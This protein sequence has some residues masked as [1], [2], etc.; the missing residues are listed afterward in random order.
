MEPKLAGGCTAA[1][2]VL[3]NNFLFVANVGDSRVLVIKE[4]AR[5]T[6]E[7][8]QLSTDDGVENEG[9]LRRLESLGLRRED[10]L[11]AGRLGTQENT[12]SI[13]DYYIKEGYRDVDSL[14]YVRAVKST[15]T[16]V[17]IISI[18]YYT[19]FAMA[20]DKCVINAN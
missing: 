9:E 13:G 17:Y 12:R 14:R 15:H 3:A 18:L 8:E 6:L 11:R 4:T 7:A 1:V 5:G 10:L 19:P 20:I 2:A 16:L